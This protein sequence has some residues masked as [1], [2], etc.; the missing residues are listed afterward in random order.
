MRIEIYYLEHYYNYHRPDGFNQ[1]IYVYKVIIDEV[2][3]YAYRPFG[4][5]RKL[6][7]SNRM[8]PIIIENAITNSYDKILDEFFRTLDFKFL[9]VVN[10]KNCL[11]KSL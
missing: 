7:L 10:I 5:K 9:Q 8:I 6:K 11:M 3:Y 2:P 1:K 4:I